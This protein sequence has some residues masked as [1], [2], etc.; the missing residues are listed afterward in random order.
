MPECGCASCVG[1]RDTQQNKLW[2][3]PTALRA[4]HSKTSCKQHV[5]SK[6]QPKITRRRSRVYR[7]LCNFPGFCVSRMYIYIYIYTGGKTWCHAFIPKFELEEDEVYKFHIFLQVR[8]IYIGGF[9][10]KYLTGKRVWDLSVGL[11]RVIVN[12][13]KE[14][15]ICNVI[16]TEHLALHITLTDVMEERLPT[17]TWSYRVRMSVGSIFKV[18]L[19]TNRLPVLTHKLWLVLSLYVFNLR[20]FSWI[21]T[22]F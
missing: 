12:W 3:S 2:R 8:F 5:F 9:Q 19:I 18:I 11:Q 14:R 22:K 15:A 17:D 13:R 10:G 1:L 7:G 4:C 6:Q 21:S 20:L 16:L